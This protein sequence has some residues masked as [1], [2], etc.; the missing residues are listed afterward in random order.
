MSQAFRSEADLLTDTIEGLPG[1]RLSAQE[2]FQ[3]ANAPGDYAL[4]IKQMAGV[5]K[6]I[7]MVH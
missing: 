6:T 4:S 2:H 3:L 7:R 1:Y 5:G